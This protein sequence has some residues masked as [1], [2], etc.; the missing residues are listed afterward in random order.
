MSVVFV[1]MYYSSELGEDVKV[2]SAQREK[3]AL[4]QVEVCEAYSSTYC[5]CGLLAHIVLQIRVANS[6]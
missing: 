1:H 3:R 4:P 2:S 5:M 6:F